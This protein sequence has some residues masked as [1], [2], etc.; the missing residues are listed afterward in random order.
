MVWSSASYLVARD[1]FRRLRKMIDSAEALRLQVNHLTAAR[2]AERIDF[3]NGGCVLF[4]GR[5][6]RAM[7]GFRA[8][9]VLVDDAGQEGPS[10][11]LDLLPC[12]ASNPNG[13]LVV[14]RG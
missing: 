4:V 14:N 13:Q 11:V 8:D 1:A 10:V 2:G 5:G 12:L 7:R 9:V 6:S 3:R